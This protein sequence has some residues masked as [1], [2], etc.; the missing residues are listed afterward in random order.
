MMRWL[1]KRGAEPKPDAGGRISLL[2]GD[3]DQAAFILRRPTRTA[4]LGSSI[5]STVAETVDGWVRQPRRVYKIE[6]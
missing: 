1:T 4:S 2:Q 6:A 3:K 5:A